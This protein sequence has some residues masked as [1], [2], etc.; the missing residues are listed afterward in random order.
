MSIVLLMKVS[1]TSSSGSEI[2]V[3]FLFEDSGCN[4]LLSTGYFCRKVK[5][6][7]YDEEGDGLS[8]RF[9]CEF[10]IWLPWSIITTCYGWL[11]FLW[12]RTLCPLSLE[13]LRNVARSMKFVPTTILLILN[14][15]ISRRGFGLF[16]LAQPDF[17]SMPEWSKDFSCTLFIALWYLS[18]NDCLFGFCFSLNPGF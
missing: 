6:G 7:N 16:I 11:V 12:I 4:L 1:D 15:S 10:V 8:C 18:S 9:I 14:E 2:L 17:S 3:N 5:C 13:P